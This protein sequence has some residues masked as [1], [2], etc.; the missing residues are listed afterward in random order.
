[1]PYFDDGEW[2]S[3]LSCFSLLRSPHFSF[4]L[5]FLFFFYSFSSYF[6]FFRNPLYTTLRDVWAKVTAR[7]LPQMECAHVRGARGGCVRGSERSGGVSHAINSES[8]VPSVL[9]PTGAGWP[10][11]GPHARAKRTS[12]PWPR[13][14]WALRGALLWLSQ[15]LRRRALLFD[16]HK[17][18]SF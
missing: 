17:T 11:P 6:S 8:S 3:L 13:A 4:L 16:D 9:V 7:L 2:L 18:F 1:M 5:S 10:T 14:V 12:A 15:F